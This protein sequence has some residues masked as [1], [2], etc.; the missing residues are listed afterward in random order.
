MQE[1]LKNVK[2]FSLQRFTCALNY[3]TAQSALKF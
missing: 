3:S 1:M 2:S